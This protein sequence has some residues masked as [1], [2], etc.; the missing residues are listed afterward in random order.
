MPLHVLPTMLVYLPICC[1]VFRCD[2]QDYRKQ[3]WLINSC[4]AYIGSH[5]E[6]FGRK[7]AEGVVVCS[8]TILLET[9]SLALHGDFLL[10][11]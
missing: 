1:F 6:L 11:Q 3:K 7:R 10:I 2:G 4:L 5:E 9:I 8:V